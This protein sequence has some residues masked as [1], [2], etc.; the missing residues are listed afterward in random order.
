[1]SGGAHS[2]HCASEAV[3]AKCTNRRTAHRQQPPREMLVHWHRHKGWTCQTPS[4]R[5]AP[6][7]P[8]AR[9]LG[10][11]GAP[12]DPVARPHAAA[13]GDADEGLTQPVADTSAVTEWAQ[14][15][16]AERLRTPPPAPPHVS[17]RRDGRRPAWGSQK[18]A[19]NRVSPVIVSPGRGTAARFHPLL[20]SVPSGCAQGAPLWVCMLGQHSPASYP[21]SPSATQ[22]SLAREEARPQSA[23]PRWR[24]APLEARR[25]SATPAAQG[26]GTSHRDTV[27]RASVA[28][29]PGSTDSMRAPSTSNSRRTERRPYRWTPL[30]RD[31][32]WASQTG[33]GVSQASMRMWR[34]APRVRLRTVAGRS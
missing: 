8:S 3:T 17:P 20:T 9:Q 32:M 31:A 11:A 33:S 15:R 7:R 18:T 22:Q 12:R 2:G 26:R 14:K 30:L 24:E 16:A 28:A 29:S 4:P 10:R 19:T 27:D 5:S 34:D 6:S 23:S 25:H 21:G 13:A 1:M